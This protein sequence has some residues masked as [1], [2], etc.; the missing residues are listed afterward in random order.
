MN[1]PRTQTEISDETR[2]R[3]A[4][5]ISLGTGIVMLIIMV[6]Y[7]VVRGSQEF[8]FDDGRLV[9][10]F[11]ALVGFFS[12][13]LARRGR[14]LLSMGLILGS[15]YAVVLI[16]S[17]IISGISPA[18]A[19]VV[20][21]V[22]LGITST[23]FPTTLANR[24]NILALFIAAVPPLIDL[25]D[26]LDI[27]K[28]PARTPDSTPQVTLATT[29]ILIVAYGIAMARQFNAYSLRIRLVLVTVLLTAL[30]VVASSAYFIY[31]IYQQTNAET[32]NEITTENGNHVTAIQNFLAGPRADVLIISQLSSLTDFL[33][34]QEA[35]TD[36]ALIAANRAKAEG[37][38]SSFFKSRDVYDQLRFIDTNGREVI[39][40]T[41]GEGISSQLEDKSARPYFIESIGLPAGSLYLSPLELEEDLGKIIV[42]H[43][44][45]L[46]YAAPVYIKNKLY[47]VVVANILAAGFL[48]GLLADVHPTILVDQD[49]YYM[50]N[51][52]ESKSWGREL[53]T[54]YSAKL[55][56][57]DL[58]SNLIS[59]Q[60]GEFTQSGQIFFYTPVILKGENAPR[61]YL[62]HEVAAADIAAPAFRVL[63]TGF[64]ILII[65]LLLT[66]GIAIFLANSLTASLISLTNTAQR[67][68]AGDL[69]LQTEVKSNDEIG[70]LARAFNHMTGQLRE[71]IGS[72]EDRVNDRTKALLTSTE[73]SRR[74]STILDEKRLV[75]EVVEQVQTAFNYYHAHIYLLDEKGQDLV[76]VGGTGEA[77]QTMLARGHKIPMGKG[78]VGR[79]AQNNETVLVPDVSQDPNWL[80]NPLLPETKSEVAVPISISD[81]VLG[82]L[83]VQHN[84]A[85]ELKQED[86]DLLESIAFQIAFAVRNARSYT[87]L[88]IQARSEMLISSISQKVQSATTLEGT[89]QVA[90]RELGRALSA[91]DTRAMLKLTNIHSKK[92]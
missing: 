36:P 8:S 82:V 15:F 61:W 92:N 43:R 83:D 50:Y 53:G 68:A 12:A 69:S 19:V 46:R 57:P 16:F 10:G 88:Q 33:E 89:L 85:G 79:A 30:G 3:R 27:L 22:T 65:A 24:V 78:L 45:V 90:V 20:L 7:L 74:L 52:D 29:G 84:V 77:G 1:E 56:F 62:A 17:L 32:T 9:S 31:Q 75:V 13:W 59:G 41:S 6:V 71:L 2:N 91:Q 37:S 38:F 4:F 49:G 40:V 54:G 25:L 76:M 28:I 63:S 72:L 66:A 39:K 18:A 67:V 42:P 80:P 55:D 35:G 48:D 60:P 51:P 58:M 64:F 44:P 26:A 87:E 5:L 14:T 34:A 86:A 21:V 70:V 81:Q 23:V 73:V 47:G 11:I